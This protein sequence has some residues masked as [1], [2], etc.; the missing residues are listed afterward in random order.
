ML[1]LLDSSN[2][3]W[4]LFRMNCSIFQVCL[5]FEILSTQGPDLLFSMITVSI[6]ILDSP[7]RDSFV[8]WKIKLTVF[9]LKLLLDLIFL[10]S[11]EKVAYQP[12]DFFFQ[13]CLQWPSYYA[14]SRKTVPSN[15]ELL[16]TASKAAARR[17]FFRTKAVEKKFF[18]RTLL[19]CWWFNLPGP[20]PIQNFVLVCN[21][22]TL[23][24]KNHDVV[25]F[26]GMEQFPNTSLAVY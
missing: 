17:N 20:N 21:A 19:R 14:C 15:I 22:F 6:E 23:L 3:L 10:P 11:Q 8:I 7:E 25:F 18:L 16:F 26:V 4:G 9:F 13:D 5:Q 12:L 1:L 2:F 24:R